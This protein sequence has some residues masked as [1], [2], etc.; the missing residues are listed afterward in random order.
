MNHLKL[1]IDYN[2]GQPVAEKL[3]ELGAVKAI[4]TIDYG[5]KQHTEDAELVRATGKHNCLLLTKDRR[6]INEDV[7]PPCSHGGVIIVKEKWPSVE[8]VFACVKALCQS[9]HRSKAA[10]HVTHLWEDRAIIHT[11][12][13]AE[14]VR[15]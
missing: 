5:F 9:G 2:L 8:R 1:M 15:L 10:H 6:T 14:E 4:T 7:Y 12:T 13:G 3:N 11:H